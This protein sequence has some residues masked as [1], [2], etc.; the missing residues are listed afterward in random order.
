MDING[1][2]ETGIGTDVPH[3]THC[4]DEVLESGGCNVGSTAAVEEKHIALS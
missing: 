1:I 3:S 4:L 2:A